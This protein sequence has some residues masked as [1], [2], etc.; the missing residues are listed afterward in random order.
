VWQEEA[1][2]PLMSDLRSR[3]LCLVPVACTDHVPGGSGNGADVWSSVAAMGLA[4]EQ[5]EE[6]GKVASATA[7]LSGGRHPRQLA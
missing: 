2:A 6:D 7:T 5:Q 1:R 4:A 3:G